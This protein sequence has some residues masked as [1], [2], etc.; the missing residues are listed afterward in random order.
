LQLLQLGSS[1]A[2]FLAVNPEAF[3]DLTSGVDPIFAD[4]TVLE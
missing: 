4:I 3:D 1:M 2:A